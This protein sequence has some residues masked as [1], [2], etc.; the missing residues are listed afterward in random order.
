MDLGSIPSSCLSNRYLFCCPQEHGDNL[1]LKAE[2]DNRQKL[3]GIL[4]RVLLLFRAARCSFSVAQWYI[5]Q[6]RWARKVMQKVWTVLIGQVLCEASEVRS[7]P[8]RCF[9]KDSWPLSL[10]IL[11]LFAISNSGQIFLAE[12]WHC[13]VSVWVSSPCSNRK[14]HRTTGS[15][16]LYLLFLALSHGSFLLFRTL[17]PCLLEVKNQ[18]FVAT[19]VVPSVDN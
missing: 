17:P 18:C 13:A 9:P 8:L 1:L 12:K 16:R 10:Q 19:S 14:C 6:L 4:Q 7:C 5:L 15:S 3:S 11:G 2:K